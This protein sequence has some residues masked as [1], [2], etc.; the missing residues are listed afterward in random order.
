MPWP[1]ACCTH[2]T[3]HPT[4]TMEQAAT[5]PTS[6]TTQTLAGAV[7]NP[8]GNLPSPEC[9]TEAGCPRKGVPTH[10]RREAG[11]EQG[12]RTSDSHINSINR[13]LRPTLYT[14]TREQ[15]Q[16]PSTYSSRATAVLP[17]THC[18]SWLVSLTR[19]SLL[20]FCSAL[21]MILATCHAGSNKTTL[22]QVQEVKL[23]SVM[24]PLRSQS[25]PQL[26]PHKQK[27]ERPSLFLTQ[28]PSTAAAQAPRESWLSQAQTQPY[29]FGAGSR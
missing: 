1:G 21:A 4:S 6:L 18:C 15:G 7:N 25:K 10:G 29:L 12:H 8:L 28:I 24:G 14:P 23:P 5:C 17:C 27:V 20:L 16:H 19:S 22:R 26:I 2:S 3:L 11:K 9:L 13:L